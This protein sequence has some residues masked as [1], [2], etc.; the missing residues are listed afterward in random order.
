MYF[1]RESFRHTIAIKDFDYWVNDYWVGDEKWLRKQI[2][3]S[4]LDLSERKFKVLDYLG[5]EG[6]DFFRNTIGSMWEHLSAAEIKINEWIEKWWVTDTEL[7]EYIEILWEVVNASDA[8]KLQRKVEAR[9]IH[10]HQKIPHKI[11]IDQSEIWKLRENIQKLWDLLWFQVSL[12]WNGIYVIN[13]DGRS[14]V[15][16]YT[17][18]WVTSTYHSYKELLLLLI[19]TEDVVLLDYFTNMFSLPRPTNYNYIEAEK[20]KWKM[21]ADRNI[22]STLEWLPQTDQKNLPE[23]TKEDDIAQVIP[24]NASWRYVTSNTHR[25]IGTFG[26]WSCVSLILQ[27]K[28]KAFLIHID[29]FT[30]NASLWGKWAEEVINQNLSNFN[31]SDLKIHVVW[32]SDGTG[33]KNMLEIYKYLENKWL[34]HKINTANFHGHW[35]ARSVVVDVESGELYPES[36]KFFY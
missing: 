12:S 21:K 35:P 33:R 26:M 17:D 31:Q 11:T 29:D 18:T 24:W 28:W 8:H 32:N 3:F 27:Q 19:A 4:D 14:V 9:V 1:E 16:C 34:S 7:E 23:D 15:F 10:P 6:K 5:E 25:Y 13:D 36:W 22:I 2:S 20:Y 30:G